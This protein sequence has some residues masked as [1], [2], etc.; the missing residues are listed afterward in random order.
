MLSKSSLSARPSLSQAPPSSLSASYKQASLESNRGLKGKSRAVSRKKDRTGRRGRPKNMEFSVARIV[1]LPYG[2]KENPSAA[3]LSRLETLNLARTDFRN[4]YSIH[5]DWDY[6]RLDSELRSLFPRLF[7]HLDRQ[8][9]VFNKAYDGTQDSGYKYMSPYLLCVKSQSEIAISGIDFPTGEDI[10]EK[11]KA[12]QV[13]CN[14]I[15]RKVLKNWKHGA[16]KGKKVVVDNTTSESETESQAT[17][18]ESRLADSDSELN[19]EQPVH[20]LKHCRLNDSDVFG[21]TSESVPVAS[22]SA[23][24]IDLTED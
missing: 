17:G 19:E 3:E 11:V 21:E 9:K 14:E 16:K 18:F 1:I 5:R 12:A 24:T 4:Y 8:P 20:R 13:T 15:S 22:T 23:T 10:Y 7:E 6:F 2:T